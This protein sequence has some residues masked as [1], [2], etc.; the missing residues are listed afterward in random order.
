MQESK[1]EVPKYLVEEVVQEGVE[2][3]PTGRDQEEGMHA[4]VEHRKYIP[5]I[6]LEVE[7]GGKVQPEVDDVNK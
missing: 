5:E 2:E 7:E 6:H 1:G 3:V 4:E